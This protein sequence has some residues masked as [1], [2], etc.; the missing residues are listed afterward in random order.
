MI[1]SYNE[2]G[3]TEIQSIF[4]EIQEELSNL[5]DNSFIIDFKNVEKIELCG[6]QLLLSLKKY[7]ESSNISLKLNNIKY[8]DLEETIQTYNLKEKLEPNL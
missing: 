6:I 5:E 3:I 4:E 7:C 1:I 2:L 8:D